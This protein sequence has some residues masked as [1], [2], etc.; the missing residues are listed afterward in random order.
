MAVG[1]TRTD[2][3][4]LAAFHAGDR[5]TLEDCYREHAPR[6]VTAARRLVGPVDAETITHEVFYRLLSSPKMRESFHGGNLGAWL[7]Q[8]AV[9]SAIDDLRR[10]RRE[11]PS[12]DDE[13][14]PAPPAQELDD[15]VD[16]KR[17]VERF[18]SERLPAEWAAVFEARFLRQ[19][20][21]RDAARELGIPRTTLVYQEERIRALLQ[22]FLLQ[23][24]EA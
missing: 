19:L 21:Q 23:E 14:S 4:W 10:R 9:R 15:E 16:A 8:V 11:A 13:G 12:P 18:R 7:S 1:P 22:R 20:P 5:T 3:Q 17:L 2:D 24:D 6:V